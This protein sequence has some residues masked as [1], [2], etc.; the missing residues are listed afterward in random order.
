[1]ANRDTTD[2]GDGAEIIRFPL[3]RTVAAAVIL[4]EHDR[5]TKLLMVTI[6]LF[7]DVRDGKDRP[8]LPSPHKAARRTMRELLHASA[9]ALR[10]L[11]GEGVER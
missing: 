10:V 8:K 9:M 5:L 6:D 7:G 4:R 11:S 3:S 2:P 1:M